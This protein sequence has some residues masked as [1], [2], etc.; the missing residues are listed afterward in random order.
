[1][2]ERSQYK[3]LCVHLLL[4]FIKFGEKA[5]SAQFQVKL[6]TGSELGKN[7]QQ[8]RAELYQALVKL[9]LIV[10]VLYNTRE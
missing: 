5:N 9:S 2:V 10:F 8:A 1:M 7:I 3:D 4:R 6:P